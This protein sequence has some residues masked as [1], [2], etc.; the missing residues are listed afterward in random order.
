MTNPIISIIDAEAQS[1]E[2]TVAGHP[3]VPLHGENMD[4]MPSDIWRKVSSKL[5]D[6]EEYGLAAYEAF[7]QHTIRHRS[8]RR[9]SCEC[10]WLGFHNQFASHV[11]QRAIR[12]LLNAVESDTAESGDV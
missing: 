9:T 5:R 6:T 7:A 3:D 4:G 8:T 2:A 12:A 11:G 10:G 1:Y